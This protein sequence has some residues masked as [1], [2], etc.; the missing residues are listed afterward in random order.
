MQSTCC[1]DDV[2]AWSSLSSCAAR[3]C[4]SSRERSAASPRSA[5]LTRASAALGR[6]SALPLAA[7]VNLK[8][9]AQKRERPQQAGSGSAH[10]LCARADGL[11]PVSPGRA[12]RN[13]CVGLRLQRALLP[14]QR[15]KPFK[16]QPTCRTCR[17]CRAETGDLTC[18]TCRA[19]PRTAASG[20]HMADASER[21]F[22]TWVGSVD[23]DSRRHVEPTCRAPATWWRDASRRP[24][25]E[26]SKCR[27][28][29]LHRADTS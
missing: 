26:V 29:R 19:P 4:C 12:E 9:S 23:D 21:H 27:S 20:R 10:R 16:R 22:D 5:A 17:A 1:C 25:T 24:R 3:C 14:W 13:S 7:T 11:V 6:S 28:D 8:L 18:R 2:A 15:P